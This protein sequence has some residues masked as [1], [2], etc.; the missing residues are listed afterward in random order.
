MLQ[1][2][3]TKLLEGGRGT[4]GMMRGLVTTAAIFR[5]PAKFV[6]AYKTNTCNR[7]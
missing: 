2:I 7:Q 1:N 3:G 4:Q 6:C 5:E